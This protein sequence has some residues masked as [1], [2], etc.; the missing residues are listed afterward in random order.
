M[1][2][3][4]SL[5][6]GLLL[7]LAGLVCSVLGAVTASE[8]ASAR[9]AVFLSVAGW[10]ALGFFGAMLALVSV[11]VAPLVE[12]NMQRTEALAPIASSREDY[13]RF[14]LVRFESSE[15]VAFA[16][17]GRKPEIFLSCAVERSLTQAQLRSVIAHEYAHLRQRH[18]WALRIAQIN[19][20][21]LGGLRPG[22]ALQRAT[23][24]LIELAADDAAARQT[25]AANLANALAVLGKAS[26]D[27]SMHLRAERLTARRWPRAA[28][29][30]LP[31]V[32]RT[33]V[34]T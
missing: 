12:L 23:T 19:A 22:R 16:V 26:G 34:R 1:A 28:R 30:R 25:G 18:W 33:T 3:F 9:E 7:V 29:R 20:M 11:S 4:G 17:P 13:G 8:S 24:I 31:N 6:Q 2:W 10:L 27:Q 5:F 32:L 14:T 21:C 15:L